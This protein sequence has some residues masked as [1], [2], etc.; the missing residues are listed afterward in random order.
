MSALPGGQHI[1]R[2]VCF[3]LFIGLLVLFLFGHTI[4]GDVPKKLGF[5]A[6]IAFI[7]I[8]YVYLE[9]KRRGEDE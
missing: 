4:K 5:G 8:L 6:A 1:M 3:F 2:T 7:I 9:I